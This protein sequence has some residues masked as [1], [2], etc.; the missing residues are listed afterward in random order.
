MG[1]QVDKED[2]LEA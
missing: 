1:S 2:T